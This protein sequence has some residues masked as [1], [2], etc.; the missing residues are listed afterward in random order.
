M[1]IGERGVFVGEINILTG[2]TIILNFTY[3]Y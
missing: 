3:E 1:Q 2:L